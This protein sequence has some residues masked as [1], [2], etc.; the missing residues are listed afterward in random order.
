VASPTAHQQWVLE[1]KWTPFSRSDTSKE[2]FW[3]LGSLDRCRTSKSPHAPPLCDPR[4][5]LTTTRASG[6][7]KFLYL[8]P[9]TP[10]FQ[11]IQK[12]PV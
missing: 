9:R 7:W 4:L 8:P 3:M 11:V 12:E 2:T 1:P 10:V 5:S 6:Y